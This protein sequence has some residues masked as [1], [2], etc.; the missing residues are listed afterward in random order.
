MKKFFFYMVQGVAIVGISLIVSPQRQRSQA[1]SQSPAAQLPVPTLVIPA[2]VTPQMAAF[3]TA[4]NQLE[5][6]RVQIWNQV[7]NADPATRAAAM[8][9]WRQQ[10]LNRIRQLEQQQ[11][12]LSH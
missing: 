1:L 4:Q 10:N 2:D 5:V 12:N 7:T 6:E 9:Q 3:L 11:K 8:Q